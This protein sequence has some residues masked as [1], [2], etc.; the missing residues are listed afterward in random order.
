MMPDGPVIVS[1]SAVRKLVVTQSVLSGLQVLSAA[2]VLGDVIGAK[3]AALFI[4]IV[5][6]VQQGVNTYI[7]KSVGEAVS[8]VDSVVTR[9]QQVTEH[10]SETVTA[11]AAAMP[12]QSASRALLEQETRKDGADG[13]S[14]L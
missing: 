2:T 1:Q 10:A 13:R 14:S 8:H 5:A 9:A 4:V 11:L 7:S 6:A 3:Y 12:A